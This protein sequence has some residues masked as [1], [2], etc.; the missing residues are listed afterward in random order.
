MNRGLNVVAFRNSENAPEHERELFYKIGRSV[1]LQ[2]RGA[3]RVP[4][5]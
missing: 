5:S 1:P 2:A 4:G 3:L